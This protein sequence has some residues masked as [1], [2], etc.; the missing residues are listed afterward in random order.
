MSVS[1][2][3][4]ARLNSSRFP[5]KLL[6]NIGT[7]TVLQCTFEKALLCKEID[8]LFVATDSEEIAAHVRSFGGSVILTGKCPNGTQRVSEALQK[9]PILQRSDLII[10]LQGDHPSTQPETLSA[11]IQALRSDK[12]AQMSTA[13]TKIQMKHD[14]LSPHIVKCVFDTSLNA[15][16]FSR[17]PIPYHA[18]FKEI[19]AYGHIGVYCYRTSFLKEFIGTDKTPN[20]KLEDLEQLGVLENGYRIKIAKVNER[21]LGIDTPEDLKRY[22][23]LL[24]TSL[25]P[26]ELSPHSAKG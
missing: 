15:L 17:S 8:S 13:V 16:Y 5:E 14:F 10:N 7:K 1:C 21:I 18:D 20:Q 6:K 4:P 24:N 23:C 3:I 19:Q 25:L 2:V 12:S 11:I 9:N 22:I 26:A